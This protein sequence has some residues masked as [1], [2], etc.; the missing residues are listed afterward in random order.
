MILLPLSQQKEEDG[1][2]PTD[3]LVGIRPTIL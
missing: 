2:H 3:K 1:L